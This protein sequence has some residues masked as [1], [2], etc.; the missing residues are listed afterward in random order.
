MFIIP[1]TQSDNVVCA[2][3]LPPQQEPSLEEEEPSVSLLHSL[4]GDTCNQIEESVPIDGVSTELDSLEDVATEPRHAQHTK[5]QEDGLVEEDLK[6]TGQVGIISDERREHYEDSNQ[7]EDEK[8]SDKNNLQHENIEPDT[9]QITANCSDEYEN[10]DALEISCSNVDL[11]GSEKSVAVSIPSVSLDK[12]DCVVPI[13][14]ERSP[15]DEASTSVKITA[16]ARDIEVEINFTTCAT[17]EVE[18]VSSPVTLSL[19]D[20]DSTQGK[21]LEQNRKVEFVEANKGDIRHKTDSTAKTATEDCVG[22]NSVMVKVCQHDETE[23]QKNDLQLE[24]LVPADME[25]KEAPNDSQC[26][27]DDDGVASEISMESS[28]GTDGGTMPDLSPEMDEMCVRFYA[29]DD[30]PPD[31]MRYDQFV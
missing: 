18:I 11:E 19:N 24:D 1:D 27:T 8:N 17:E 20:G 6:D 10:S 29:S 21:K 3:D 22:T 31:L 13:P 9:V 4:P 16:E 12:T 23:S 15:A 26:L 5:N 7:H 2:T 30:E 25:T 28:S 14:E